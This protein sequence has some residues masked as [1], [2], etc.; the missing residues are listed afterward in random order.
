M[1]IFCNIHT[2]LHMFLD[3]FFSIIGSDWMVILFDELCRIFDPYDY[4][5]FELGF[6]EMILKDIFSVDIKFGRNKK[7]TSIWNC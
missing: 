5:D 7:I 1:K 2:T 4:R 3:Q 6:L